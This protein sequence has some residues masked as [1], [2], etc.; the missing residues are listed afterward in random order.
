MNASLL[1][2]FSPKEVDHALAHMNPLKALDPNGFGVCFFQRH[3]PTV[4]DSFRKAALDFL[5][6]GIFDH[7]VNSTFIV[8]IPKISPP[9]SI[10]DFRPINVVYKIVA[11]VL[12]NRLKQVLPLVIS[13]HQNAFVPGKL[14]TNNILVAQGSPYHA[15]PNVGGEMIHRPLARYE[16]GL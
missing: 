12:A 3:W 6:L 7:S 14:I 9:S 16:Q 10:S 2:P 4:G 15:H 13:Q 8:L 11:K 1:K 5:N